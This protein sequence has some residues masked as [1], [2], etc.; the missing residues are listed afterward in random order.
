MTEVIALITTTSV[1]PMRPR[2]PPRARDDGGLE[3]RHDPAFEGSVA[4]HPVGV[5]GRD[6]VDDG[7][8]EEHS[9]HVA[10][11]E[12]PLGAEP[13]RKRGRRLVRV[14]VQRGAVPARAASGATTGMRP[15]ASA[16]SIGAGADGVGS[17]TSPRAST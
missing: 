1:A 3:L 12:D 8:A 17:P 11:E 6:A 13:D 4:D 10:D 16:S 5:V 9:R 2:T 7:P 14:D 15:A